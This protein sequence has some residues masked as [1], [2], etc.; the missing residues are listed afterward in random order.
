MDFVHKAERSLEKSFR[1]FPALPLKWRETLAKLW[2]LFAFIGGILQLIAA[3]D[4][5][6][7]SRRAEHLLNNLSIYQPA[8]ADVG[9]SFVEKL[10]LYLGILL[11]LASGIVLLMAVSPLYNKL[12]K[13]WDLAFLAALIGVAYSFANIFIYQR[14]VSNFLGGLIM[15]GISFYLLFQIKDS[16][17][18]HNTPP[19]GP[20]HK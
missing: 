18:R 8:Y 6:D 10:F 5:W 20:H 2:P 7:V 17:P 1:E 13:G 16:F 3:S 9:L 14:G 4:L 12:R 19:A 15:A 11:L